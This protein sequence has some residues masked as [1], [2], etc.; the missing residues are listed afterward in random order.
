MERHDF[1]NKCW[2]CGN[3][4]DS[5]EHKH[6]K[7]DIK[8]LYGIDFEKKEFPYLDAKNGAQIIQGLNSQLLKYKKVICQKCNNERS[9]PFDRAY[10]TFI[11]YIDANIKDLIQTQEIDFSDIFPENTMQNKFYVLKYYLKHFCCLLAQNNLTIQNDIIDF[12]DSKTDI[13]SYVFIKFEIRYDNFVLEQKQKQVDLLFGVGKGPLKYYFGNGL[14]TFDTISYFY[15]YKSFRIIFI[16][17]LNINTINYPKLEKYYEKIRVP[18]EV[19]TVLGL[20]EQ[21]DRSF[22]ELADEM[23]LIKKN[24]DLNKDKYY[25]DFVANIFRYLKEVVK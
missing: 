25:E 14:D 1:E 2:L 18:I 22:E 23:S 15:N 12:I 6:K 4:A 5:Q 3:I 13:L 8:R 20:Y 24:E 11:T 16:Y 19:L 17:S 7:T 9:Q 21:D 10:D